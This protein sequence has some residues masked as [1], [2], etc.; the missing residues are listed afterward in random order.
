[1]KT[2]HFNT[3][4]FIAVFI[5]A[6]GTEVHVPT[7][8]S[9]DS[10]PGIRCARGRRCRRPYPTVTPTP[11]PTPSPIPSR[12]PS[13]T[14][15]PT[16]LPASGIGPVMN[17]TRFGAVYPNFTGVTGSI[18]PETFGNFFAGAMANTDFFRYWSSVNRDIRRYNPRGAYLKHLNLRTIDS[19]G[20]DDHPDYNW[21][22]AN[23]PEWILRDANGNTVSLFLGGEEL[24]D[25]GN[26]AYLDYALNTWLPNSYFDINDRDPSVETWY[27]HDNGDFR[28]TNINCAPQDSVCL[29]YTTANGVQ[30]AWIHMLDRFKSR[31]PNKKI[32][33]SSGTLSY[34][35][36]ADQLAVLQSVFSH[37]DGYFGECLVNRHCYWNSE[38]NSAKRVA[39]TATLQFARWLA[40][41]GKL[42]FPTY[43]N[44]V[45][46][47]PNQADTNY[48][49]AFFNL[50]RRGDKQIF[51]KLTIDSMGRYQP[52]TYPEMFLELGAAQ[53]D[54][55]QISP[56]VYRRAFSNALSYVNLSDAAVVISLPTGSFHTSTGVAVST[57]ITVG[58][59]DGITLYRSSQ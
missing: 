14:P 19:H 27:L 49:W 59:F 25:F 35:P 13:P 53:E 44:A 57:S 51:N 8:E 7:L 42:F 5:T 28:G 11:S 16:P 56:N 2:S 32:I 39:M 33:I 38:P 40:D 24:L 26:D 29:R 17:G 50:L 34:V 31:W 23:H 12:T 47:A 45:G 10:L 58:S 4:V 15:S 6:C 9:G 36:V 54:A 55:V 43:G 22:H 1:M 41:N 21:I 37:A 30:S 3:V 48:G 18:T 20:Y 52:A 46:I